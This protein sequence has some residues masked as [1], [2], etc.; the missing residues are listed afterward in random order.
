MSINQTRIKIKD[1]SGQHLD[2][3]CKSYE[4][5]IYGE[6]QWCESE[7]HHFKAKAASPN[8]HPF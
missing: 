1:V 8:V 4:D 5:L 6:E 2:E 7:L 3:Y